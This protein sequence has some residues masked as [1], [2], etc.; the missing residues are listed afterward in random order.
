MSENG[1][2]NIYHAIYVD[3]DNCTGCTHCLKN[4][5][6]RAIRIRSGKA[7]IDQNRCIDCGECIR[8]CHANAVKVEQGALDSI[9]K[10]KYRV[11]LVPAVLSGQFALDVTTDRIY[12]ALLE[13][14]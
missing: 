1:G 11:A 12:A 10:Y 5:P 3:G 9:F 14:G 6:T 8:V 2:Q 13:L 7:V 4:C